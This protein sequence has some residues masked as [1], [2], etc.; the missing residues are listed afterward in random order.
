MSI[1]ST[2]ELLFNINANADDATEN[3]AKFRTLMGKD[4]SDLGG[5]FQ[6]WSDEVLGE[7][8]TVQAAMTAGFAVMAAGLLAVAA[9]AE[10]ASKKY[11]EYALEVS[12]AMKLTGTTAE[13]MSMLHEAAEQ[14]GVSFETLTNGMVKFEQSIVKASEETSSSSRR[15]SAS[16]FHSPT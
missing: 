5:E 1:D 15:F 11:N 12:N 2:A 14:S 3:I 10:E 6:T 16:G 7:I 9:G 13:N 8:T 4:L